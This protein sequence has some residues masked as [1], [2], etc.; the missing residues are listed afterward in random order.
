MA[1]CWTSTS[2][3]TTTSMEEYYPRKIQLSTI[4]NIVIIEQ[5]LHACIKDITYAYSLYVD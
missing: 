5:Y 2:V 4:R 1:H 3:T